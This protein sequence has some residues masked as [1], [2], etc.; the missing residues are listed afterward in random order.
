[1]AVGSRGSAALASFS[2]AANSRNGSS[3]A[4]KSPLVNQLGCSIGAV[5]D[6]LGVLAWPVEVRRLSAVGAFIM[7]S[8]AS[9]LWRGARRRRPAG[10]GAG[11]RRLQHV[12]P[13]RFAVRRQRQVRHHRLDHAAARHQSEQP[14]AARRRSRLCAGRRQRTAPARREICQPALGKSATGARGTVTPIASAYSQDGAD[15]PRFPGQLRQGQRAK[16]GCRAKPAS[17]STGA[18]QVRSL[19]PWKRS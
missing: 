13:A 12:L 14:V 8:P 7:E 18:W 9:R 11:E 4:V 17:T 10:A 3:A 15:L 5:S 6:I 2:Q 16:P 1:M 19:K